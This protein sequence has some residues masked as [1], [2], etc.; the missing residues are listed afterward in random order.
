MIALI[1]YGLGNLRSVEKAL[2]AVGAEVHL[3]GDPEAVR[4]ADRLI[5]PGVGA[6]GDGMQG[7]QSRGLEKAVKAA[8]QAGTPLLG[9]CLGM[10][11]LF[12]RSKEA[13]GR[14]GLGLLP[15]EVRRFP[16]EQVPGQRAASERAASERQLKVP[17]TGWNQLHIEGAPPLLAGL[18]PGAYAYFNHSFYCAPAE[19][20]DWL[21]STDY[22]LR[23]ASVVG[24]GSLFGVQF[25]PEKSQ[26]VGLQILHNFVRARPNI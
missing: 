4:R 3:A 14:P 12:E 18:E 19:N 15:G 1:D 10:Q 13:P 2:Q 23:Y 22:G 16:Q 21:A 5:L 11:L 20:S 17:Q 7:L 8:V 9:I 6:F 24:R 26:S 25:H